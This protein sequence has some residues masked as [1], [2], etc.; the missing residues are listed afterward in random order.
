[1]SDI[2]LLPVYVIILNDV[3][4]MQSLLGGGLSREV[5]LYY[6]FKQLRVLH[7]PSAELYV[8]QLILGF[9]AAVFST[10]VISIEPRTRSVINTV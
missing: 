3:C 7:P 4:K 5:L 1:M 8:A 2:Y 9:V 10:S 6:G